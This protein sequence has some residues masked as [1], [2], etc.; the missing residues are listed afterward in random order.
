MVFLRRWAGW[1]LVGYYG[2][3]AVFVHVLVL[4]LR[5]NL[6]VVGVLGEGGLPLVVGVPFG[7]E[8][9]GGVIF[10]FE[11]PLARCASWGG[12]GATP[13]FGWYLSG[14]DDNGHRVSL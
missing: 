8:G 14:W 10:R 5:V 9:C 4:I 7:S 12:G 13:V 3:A 11:V 6:G 2:V 1:G